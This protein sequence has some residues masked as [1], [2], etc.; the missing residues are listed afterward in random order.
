M[1]CLP[2]KCMRGKNDCSPLSNI[3]SDDDDNGHSFICVGENNPETRTVKEDIYTLCTKT[4]YVDDICNLD[5]RDIVD[6]VSVM[7]RA[8]SVIENKST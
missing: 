4:E 3:V 5:Y 8:L 2:D 6:Q 7:A 1:I